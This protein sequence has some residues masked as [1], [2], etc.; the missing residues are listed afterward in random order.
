STSPLTTTVAANDDDSSLA[1]TI[2]LSPTLQ[3]RARSSSRLKNQNEVSKA[4]GYATIIILFVTCAALILVGILISFYRRH[5]KNTDNR[6]G[7]HLT[8]RNDDPIYN[9]L[10]TTGNDLNFN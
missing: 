2:S 10:T 7:Y 3:K 6:V 8:R 4:K 9:P 1:A 5:L